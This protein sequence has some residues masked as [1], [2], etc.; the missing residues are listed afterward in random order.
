MKLNTS[1]TIKKIQLEQNVSKAFAH[2]YRTKT[3]DMPLGTPEARQNYLW[4]VQEKAN[5]MHSVTEKYDAL[6][7]NCLFE[8][9][10][11]DNEAIY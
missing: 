8:P 3:N 11:Q 5:F 6:E 1:E 7:E 9:A 10:L 4:H 2:W